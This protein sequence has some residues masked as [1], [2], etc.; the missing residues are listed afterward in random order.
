[1]LGRRHITSHTE[2]L[3]TF[4]LTLVATMDFLALSI[5][6]GLVVV[7]TVAGLLWRSRQ[8]AITGGGEADISPTLLAPGHWLTLLQVSAP[9]CSYCSAMRGILQRAST[10]HEGVA[11]VEYD[12][13][14]IPEVIDKFAV[15]QTPTTFLVEADGRVVHQVGG[16]IAP[17]ALD[18]LITQAR[19]DVRKRSDEYEI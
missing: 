18:Q 1:M 2:G 16:P 10:A 8:G 6:A 13:S 3:E 9:L 11:H 15:R 7:S 17:P 4:L 14:E 5:L 19:E 12:V